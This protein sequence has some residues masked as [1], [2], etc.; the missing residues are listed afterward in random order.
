MGGD[1][2]QEGGGG[3]GLAL[4][5]SLCEGDIFHPFPNPPPPGDYCT[6]PKP[7]ISLIPFNLHL[8]CFQG[9]GHC[10]FFVFPANQKHS[11]KLVRDRPK[12][13]KI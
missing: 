13:D 2:F 6:V 8:H 12:K 11:F 1:V 7:L 5:L 3:G 4:I 9:L 10:Y